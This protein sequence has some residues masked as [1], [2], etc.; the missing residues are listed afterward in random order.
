[1]GVIA[2]L[3]D[4]NISFSESATSAVSAFK[5]EEKK[6]K[7]LLAGAIHSQRIRSCDFVELS[8]HC[9]L[10]RGGGMR[11]EEKKRSKGSY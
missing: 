3:P 1:M 6:K 5:K 11:P 8:K 2:V 10:A 4:L 9:S 7:S